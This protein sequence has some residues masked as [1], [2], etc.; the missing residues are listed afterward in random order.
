MNAPRTIAAGLSIALAIAA[1]VVPF[2]ALAD[3]RR[4][5]TADPTVLPPRMMYNPQVARPLD[6]RTIGEARRDINAGP[7]TAI[8][9]PIPASPQ[10]QGASAH[11]NPLWGIPLTSLTSTHERPLFS[12]SRRPRAVARPPSP[13][14]PPPVA[15]E[16][17]RPVLSLVGA[18][19]AKDDSIALLFDPTTK[20]VLRLKIGES[21]VG[22]TLLRVDRQEATLQRGNESIVFAT[23]SARAR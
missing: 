20:T 15:V 3:S 16:Q 4:M 1:G 6:P 23:P 19:V 18:I 2:G 9:A 22:W 10:L 7:V 14:P 5:M 12:A 21:H 11:G 17:P 8:P 13:P